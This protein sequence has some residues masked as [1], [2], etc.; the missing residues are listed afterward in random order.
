MRGGPHQRPHR[1]EL[2]LGA[3]RCGFLHLIDAHVHDLELSVSNDQ[4]VDP[5]F[6]AGLDHG[7]C[8]GR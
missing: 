3:H 4:P 2:E 1:A 6:P 8:L 7:Q 5:H